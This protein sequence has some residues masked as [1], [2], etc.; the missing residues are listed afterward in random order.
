MVRVY[1]TSREGAP[2][3][4]NFGAKKASN[5]AL[6][7]VDAHSNFPLGWGRKILNS[8]DENQNCMITP[9]VTV[10]GDD[11]SRGCGFKWENI[12]MAIAWLPDLKPEIHEIPFAC[13]C[14][15][16]V[17]KKVFDE[18]GQFDSGIR[19]WGDE[20][21][22]ISMRAWLMGYRVLCDPSIRVG[23]MFRSARPYNLEWSDTIYNKMRFVIS[24]FKSE[25]ISKHLMA[26][27]SVPDFGK[28]L[29]MTLQ[30]GVLERR[31]TLFNNRI[32]N[33]DWFF[34]KYPM[35]N[36]Q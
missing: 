10:M 11:N 22:E 24:H 9:C 14:C 25:R 36:W 35:N 5:D 32:Y 26:L 13:G 19:F 23:H 1:N 27:S 30:N 28:I 4:R 18:I 15:I 17:K 6:I 21:S 31:F 7:F 20:D 3:A 12:L 33:D 34:R 8:L 2:Q 16:A 29:L